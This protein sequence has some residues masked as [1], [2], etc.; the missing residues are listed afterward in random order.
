MA[1]KRVNFV[2]IAVKDQDR[3]LK[4]YC[5]VLGF[6]VQTDAPMGD[7][8]RWIFLEVPGSETMLQ[9][10]K[11]N[12]ISVTDG[13]P[14]LALVSNDVD[15]EMPGLQSAGVTIVDGPADAPWNS[16]VRYVLIKD[17]EGNTILLQSS[18]H[19]GA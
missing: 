9:F 12:E 3:A 10:S 7:A 13:H 15:A 19:E 11:P 5:D 1:V 16:D 2:S 14:A 6:Q 17:S 18:I 8:W 4:F